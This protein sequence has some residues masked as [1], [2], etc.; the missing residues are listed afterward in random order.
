MTKI[1]AIERT[2]KLLAIACSL[3]ANP[4]ERDVAQK[5][6]DALMQKHGLVAS[7]LTVSSKV[8]AFDKL[9]DIMGEYTSKHPD[10]KNN[11]FGAIQVIGDLLSRSK[12]DIAPSAKAALLDKI[13]SG[14][15]LATSFFGTSN[16]TLVDLKAIVDSVTKSFN[17]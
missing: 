12:K 13:S 6:A 8:A 3:T 14:L 1:Q 2:N 7:D 9:V 16:R 5:Q 15:G 4:H 11:S 10:L 17:L